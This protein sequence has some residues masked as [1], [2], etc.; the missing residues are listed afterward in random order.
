MRI[1]DPTS[2]A[3]RTESLVDYTRRN[4]Q[5][6]FGKLDEFIDEWRSNPK[7]EA[8]R[9]LFRGWGVD[10]EEFKEQ[11]KMTNYD[12]FDFI[13]HLAYNQKPLTRK[14]RAQRVK[15]SGWLDRFVNPAREVLEALLDKYA[16]N[17]VYE[18]EDIAVLN[19]EPFLKMGKLS[20]IVSYFG[21]KENYLK[22][23]HELAQTIYK[24]E[25]A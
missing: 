24:G 1:Y 9:E 14:E 10:L 3:L 2:D 8:I 18:I 4:V 25:A 22:T 6:Q 21:G 7:K 11:E 16:D 12:D 19:L 17:G 5:G 23:V 15:Q 20:R 13:C